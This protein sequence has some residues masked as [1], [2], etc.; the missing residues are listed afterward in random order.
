MV[1]HILLV[2]PLGYTANA[3]VHDIARIANIMPPIGLAS[4]AAWLDQH[5]FK[6]TIVDCYAK[7]DSQ[8][9]IQQIIQ[10]QHPA[11]L[12]LSC[13]TSSFLD[14]VKMAEWAKSLHPAIKTVMGGPHISAL[15][16]NALRGYA[17]LDFGVVGEG[18]ETFA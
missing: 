11:F 6:T 18:E 17:S 4:L 16:A 10:D 3:A 1:T 2:H 15:K 13:T 8:S 7:P 9:R 14:G 12:G 5:G